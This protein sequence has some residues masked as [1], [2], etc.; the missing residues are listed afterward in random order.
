LDLFLKSR[1]ITNDEKTITQSS[2]RFSNPDRHSRSV[3][4]SKKRARVL[5]VLGC[6]NKYK[7]TLTTTKCQALPH[8]TETVWSNYV[9]MLFSV[10]YK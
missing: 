10:N 9:D 5:G 8:N 1:L 3:F 7:F 6:P 4:L 2:E